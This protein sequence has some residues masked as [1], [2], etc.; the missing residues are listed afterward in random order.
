MDRIG[1]ISLLKVFALMISLFAFALFIYSLLV[2]ETT[3]EFGM[4]TMVGFAYHFYSFL[5][6]A[7]S[8]LLYAIDALVSIVRIL[9]RNRPIFHAVLA[10]V[11]LGGIPMWFFVGAG[12]ELF[13]TVVWYTYYLGICVLEVISIVKDMRYD[14]I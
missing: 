6:C 13:E 10:L 3:N 7:A 5:T 12:F 2:E 9:Q 8:L 1:K 11:L 14:V 4:T